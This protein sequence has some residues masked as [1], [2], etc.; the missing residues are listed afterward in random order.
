MYVWDWYC[1]EKVNFQPR[2]KFFAGSNR[3]SNRCSPHILF[4]MLFKKVHFS[5]VSPESRLPLVDG[6]FIRHWNAFNTNSLFWF[7]LIFPNFNVFPSTSESVFWRIYKKC[8]FLRPC[9]RSEFLISYSKRQLKR[10]TNA[11]EIYPR[12]EKRCCICCTAPAGSFF[13]HYAEFIPTG[14]DPT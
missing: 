2:L 6:W 1:N 14:R 5:F 4:C 13:H 8:N 10:G 9:M 11:A 3:F 12:S 7:N